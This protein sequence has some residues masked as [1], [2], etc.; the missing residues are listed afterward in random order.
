MRASRI[1]GRLSSTHLRARSADIV[2]TCLGV[3]FF[4]CSWSSILSGEEERLP[5]DDRHPV[6]VVDDDPDIRETLRDVIDAEGFVVTCAENGREALALL[7][8]GLR[9]AL[10]VL[11]LMMPAMSGWEVLA[12]IRADRALADLPVAV[13]SAAGARAAPAGATWFLRKPI[14]LDALLALLDVLRDPPGRAARRRDRL[15][16]APGHLN[17]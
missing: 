6:L 1:G 5:V 3:R 11:D 4:A 9:P 8:V 13:M 17:A 2:Y 10:V 12:A 14:D 7:G 15:P 16:D